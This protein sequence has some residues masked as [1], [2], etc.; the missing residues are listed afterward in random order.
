M[1]AGILATSALI[2][3]IQ[4]AT[5][6][7]ITVPLPMATL[8]RWLRQGKTECTLHFV[9]D[10]IS[11]SDVNTV[12]TPSPAGPAIPAEGPSDWITIKTAAQKLKAR[13]DALAIGEP[14]ELQSL[15]KRVERAV[16]DGTIAASGPSRSRRLDAQSF[17]RWSTT[18]VNACLDELDGA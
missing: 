17:D 11:L 3:H 8:R 18:Y 4:C 2:D 15:R 16:N 6:E 10:D 12:P 7:G 5:D 9:F 13:L 1:A 14:T